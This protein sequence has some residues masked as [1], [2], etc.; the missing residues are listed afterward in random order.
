[1]F[2][3][4]PKQFNSNSHTDKKLMS[5]FSPCNNVIIMM[6]DT[7]FVASILFL[8]AYFLVFK[9]VVTV[10]FVTLLSLIKIFSN[11]KFCFKIKEQ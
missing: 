5:D 9:S 8:L 11:R 3:A 10:V 6:I 7:A 1:M 2:K 4:M